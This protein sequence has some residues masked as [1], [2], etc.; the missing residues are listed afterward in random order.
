MGEER[1]YCLC[2]WRV[3]SAFLLP[4][5]LP[6]NG[7][8][9][10]PVDV[11]I[12]AGTLPQ[13]LA[14]DGSP[15]RMVD[16]DASTVHIPGVVNMQVRNGRDIIVDLPPKDRDKPDWHVFLLGTGLVLLCYQRRKFPLHAAALRIGE[17]TIAIA[18]RSGAGK[19]TLALALSQRGHSLLSDDLAVLRNDEPDGVSVLPA[20]PRLKLWADTLDWA[21][22]ST[23]R[24]RRVRPRQ[25]KYDL[26]A[27][28][29]F[30][31]EATR[32]DAVIHLGKP[33]DAPPRLTPMTQPQSIAHLAHHA[34]RPWMP[35]P[36][37]YETARLTQAA[38]IARAVPLLTLTRPL[39][40]D[41][42]S[43]TAARIEDLAQADLL[44]PEPE[45]FTLSQH[46]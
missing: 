34:T 27:S 46:G 32:L 16:I 36:D 38:A 4:E 17:R 10:A 23:G 19:S 33:E 8:T 21:G 15:G 41:A 13:R 43:T 35:R 6:W 42:V 44:S 5:L 40:F 11:T 30:T 29:G 25:N 14:A 24:L 18:G 3:R 7:A 2:G 31:P 26:A 1:D 45:F 37:G 39:R 28:T 12:R 22:V 9:N 20:F